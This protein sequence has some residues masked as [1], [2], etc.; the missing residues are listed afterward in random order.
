MRQ[1][2]QGR[3]RMTVSRREERLSSTIYRDSGYATSKKRV[4]REAPSSQAA[5]I[6]EASNIHDTFLRTA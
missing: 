2:G 5:G 6:Y 1:D 4:K 3:S